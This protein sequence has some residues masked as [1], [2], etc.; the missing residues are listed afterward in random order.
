MLFE[1][2]GSERIKHRLAGLASSPVINGGLNCGCTQSYALICVAC[3][4]SNKG[5]RNFT[6]SWGNKNLYVNHL[7]DSSTSIHTVIV[8]LQSSWIFVYSSTG[9]AQLLILQEICLKGLNLHN[10]A[11]TECSNVALGRAVTTLYNIVIIMLIF[12]LNMHCADLN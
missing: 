7:P 8:K 2:S 1:S 6:Q 10:Y 3:I 5:S 11:R 12:G 4:A 9:L